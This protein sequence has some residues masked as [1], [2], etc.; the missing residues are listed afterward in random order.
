MTDNAVQGLVDRHA[1]EVHVD[2]LSID[3]DGL[4]YELFKSLHAQ[5]FETRPTI[6]LVETNGFIRPDLDKVLSSIIDFAGTD[7]GL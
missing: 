4:D 6:V 3:V 2:I 1:G 7:T 5:T